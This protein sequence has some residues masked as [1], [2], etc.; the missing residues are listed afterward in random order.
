MM[1]H[2]QEEDDERERDRKINPQKKNHNAWCKNVKTPPYCIC[3]VVGVVGVGER[4]RERAERER[5]GRE[6]GA[7]RVFRAPHKL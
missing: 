6:R 4:E 2:I 3:S 5:R 1:N 7:P